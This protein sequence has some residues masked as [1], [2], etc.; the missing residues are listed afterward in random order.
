MNHSDIIIG[1]CIILGQ[2]I[3]V[4][5]DMATLT[6]PNQ[7]PSSRSDIDGSWCWRYPD[8]VYSEPNFNH[9]RQEVVSK[10]PKQWKEVGYNLGLK[11]EELEGIEN[12]KDTDKDRFTEVLVLWKKQGGYEGVYD[13]KWI[14]L[15]DV[16]KKI[17]EY[18]LE[19][20]LRKR[21]TPQGQ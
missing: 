14:T 10:I 13:Y 15:L 17:G 2:F 21:L 6:H 1:A 18:R 5:P 19:D 12:E 16:L 3:A 4:L 8:G 7:L 9:L 20:E 11:H